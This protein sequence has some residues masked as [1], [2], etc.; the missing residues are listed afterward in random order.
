M[1]A[2]QNSWKSTLEFFGLGHANGNGNANIEDPYAQD[3]YTRG[4]EEEIAPARAPHLVP[5]HVSYFSEARR[6]AEPVRQGEIVAL[7]LRSMD[8]DSARRVVDFAAGISIG[9]HGEITIKQ[10]QERVFAIIPLGIDVT[11]REILD[12]I[13]R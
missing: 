5:V 6:I 7:D 10:I 13:R 12:A 11:D 1:A 2:L 3:E 9:V 4:N 8:L